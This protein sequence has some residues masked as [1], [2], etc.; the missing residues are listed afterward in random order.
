MTKLPWDARCT[1][2]GHGYVCVGGAEQGNFA[3]IKV[4]VFPPSDPQHVDS[5]LPLDLERHT[6]VSRPPTLGTPSQIQLEK[7]G[8]DIVNSISIHK[9]TAEEDGVEQ[10]VAVLTNNDKTVRLYSLTLSLEITVLDLPFPMNHA[11][12]SPDGKLLVAVGDQNV[13]Y[14]FEQARIP[15]PSSS[16]LPADR[17]HSMSPPDWIPF[18]EVQLYVPPNSTIEGYFTTAWSPSCRFCAVGSECG[19]ITVF[20]TELLFQCDNGEDAVVQ[21]IGSTRPENTI[22]PGAV[23]TMLFSPAPWDLLIWSE[24]QARV[25]VADLRSGLRTRQVLHLDPK[26]E[27]LEKVEIADFDI[28]LSPES[29]LRQET[30]FVRRYRR[31]L[32]SEDAAAVDFATDFLEASNERRRQHRRL[33]IVESDD[34][35]HG[36]TAHERQIL[37]ALRST[38]Q[39]EENR[40]QGITPRSIHYHTAAAGSPERR[41]RIANA[42]S[43]A[44]LRSN[45]R[46]RAAEAARAQVSDHDHSLAELLSES[47]RHAYLRRSSIA[48]GN[49]RNGSGSG[50][51]SNGTSGNSSNEN[52][53]DSPTTRSPGLIP[54]YRRYNAAPPFSSTDEAWA[55]IEDALGRTV[56]ANRAEDHT[57]SNRAATNRSFRAMR[58]RLRNLHGSIAPEIYSLG[59]V[60]ASYQR[61]S[62]SAQHDPLNGVRTAGLAISQDGQTLFCGTEEGIFEFKI[63]LQER[64]CCPAIAP[65]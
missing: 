55:T 6:P 26:A 64:K 49:E 32:G 16:K 20:D 30:D 1:A 35:P 42:Y 38:R 22:G 37:E 54:S 61:V 36:L 24:D 17:P 21:I 19:Y 18:H 33:G 58:E 25:C 63:N 60:G 46:A 62:R 52:I 57:A 48:P 23:R 65:C 31:T 39:R 4:E 41:Y 14:F 51:N 27:D 12:I 44:S 28:N 34:D 50:S 43:L 29:A 10:V 13:A 59:T 7:I 11:T 3:A 9:F 56:N 47:A 53:T 45:A 5:R 40:E 15:Q 2:S 8:E